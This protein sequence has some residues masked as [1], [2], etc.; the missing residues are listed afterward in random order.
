LRSRLKEL[1]RRKVLGSGLGHLVMKVLVGFLMIMAISAVIALPLALLIAQ[2][3]LDAFAFRISLSPWLFATA[4]LMI[5]G[6]MLLSVSYHAI[7]AI[8]VNVLA[9]LRREE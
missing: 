8:R 5:L 1:A 3:W 7:G 6:L 9:H 2:N 4:L